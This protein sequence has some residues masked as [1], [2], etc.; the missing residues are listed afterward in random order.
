MDIIREVDGN[1]DGKIELEE[2]LDIAA[3]V[4]ELSLSSAF[5]DIVARVGSG[6]KNNAYS[7]DLP[8]EK[9]GGGW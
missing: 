7:N 6:D 3:G 8:P 2:F 9:S 5:S 1:K 4:K